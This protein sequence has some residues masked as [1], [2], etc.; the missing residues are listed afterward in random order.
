MACSPWGRTLGLS[1]WLEIFLFLGAPMPVQ[2]KGPY[3]NKGPSWTKNSYRQ[4][5]PTD[6][7]PINM[8]CNSYRQRA[9]TDNLGPL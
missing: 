6:K 3:I 8:L 1:V 7:G 5:A 4:G 2:I 9:L